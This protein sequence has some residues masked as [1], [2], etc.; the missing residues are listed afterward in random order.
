MIPDICLLLT[1]IC[2][3]VTMHNRFKYIHSNK[4]DLGLNVMLTITGGT[5]TSH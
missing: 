5:Y 4:S 2:M 1:L 3:V